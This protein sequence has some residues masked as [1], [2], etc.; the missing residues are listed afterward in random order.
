MQGVEHLGG[1]GPPRVRRARKA[2]A[3]IGDGAATA[4]VVTHNLNTRDVQVVIYES[5][6][7][8]AEIETDV[9]HTDVNSVTIR[10]AVAPAAN[11][12]RVTIQG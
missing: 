8:Y 9:E 12:Y 5:G 6:S 3:S 1:G 7:P 11:A 10:F 4:Y 2:A